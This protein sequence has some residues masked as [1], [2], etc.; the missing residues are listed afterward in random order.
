VLILA[1]AAA[2]PVA[3]ATT[4]GQSGACLVTTEGGDVQGLN[5]GASCAFL[6]VP[7]AAPPLGSRRWQAPEPA[8]AWAPAVAQ[9]TVVPP[10][11]TASEDCLKLNIWTP[12]PKP[13][14]A[15]VIV[16]L[17]TGS[18]VAAS[19]S[20]GAHNG[21]TLAQTTGAIVV[22]PNYR[23]AAFGFLAHPALTAEHGPPG[24]SGN[25]GLLDQRAALAWVRDNIAAFG[26]DPGTIT[27]AG[28]SAGGHSVGMHLVSPASAGL[29]QRAVMQSG[30]ASTRLPS[31]AEAEAQGLAFATALGCTDAASVLTC[32]RAAT[33][34]QVLQALPLGTFEFNERPTHW[35]PNVDG[36]EL[37]DQPR[38]LYESGAFARVPI[39][40]GV[41]RDEGWTWVTRSFAASMTAADYEAAL[42]AEF[43]ADGPLVLAQYPAAAFPTP[44]DALVRVTGDAE[45][46]CEA[47]RLARLI[48]RTGTP[49]YL[50]SFEYEVDAIVVDRVVHGLESNFVF[51]NDFGPPL[52]ASYPLSAA[53]RELARAMGGYWTRFAATG[54]PNTDDP[55]VVHW[56]AFKH[57]TGAGR[58]ADKHLILSAAIQEGQRLREA[59]CAFWSPYFFRSVTGPVPAAA[60]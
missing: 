5:Q 38:L 50:Y 46:S 17:H 26:G 33:R 37:P 15:P 3:A 2:L 45:Y 10:S 41:T 32:L 57:P 13:D 28:T 6:G 16:W 52:I 27:L 4:R 18:F 54:S 24:S 59:E 14:R 55:A 1:C 35:T 51:G 7:F 48:E 23:L 31:L 12:N 42:A 53:D 44:R 60:P 43:G 39:L 58:G 25:Y 34:T 47:A 19:A 30:F 9:A 29:F 21:R 20:F 40:L 49:V 56:P 22:A 11:C 8:A 36:V